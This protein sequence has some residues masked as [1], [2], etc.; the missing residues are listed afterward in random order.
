MPHRTYSPNVLIENNLHV[1]GD[2]TIGKISNDS[3]LVDVGG[4]FN[5]DTV[6]EPSSADVANFVATV[7]NTSGNVNNGDHTYTVI[8]KTADGGETGSY[9]SSFFKTI[10]ITDNT[11]A[12]QVLLTGIPISTDERVVA[13][14]IYRTSAND[15]TFYGKKLATLNDN[16]TTTFT[17]V[18]S[19]CSTATSGGS[20][21]LLRPPARQTTRW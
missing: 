18:R 16:T 20:S 8:Y 19:R 9:T 3:A 13:R 6:A 12:G 1:K 15:S 4:N 17:I 5:F 14:D 7:Q 11:V 10:T 21:T 2:L